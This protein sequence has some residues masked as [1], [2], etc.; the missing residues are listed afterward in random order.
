MAR[1]TK[2][3][4]YAA[5]W[6]RDQGKTNEEIAKELSITIKQV[7]GVMSKYPHNTQPKQDVA[8]IRTSKDFMIRKTSAKENNTVAIMT[9]EA[10]EMN[11]EAKKKN[12]SR[13][14]NNTS[15]IHRIS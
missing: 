5:L 14:K 11:D 7:D 3:Q 13:V 9:K 4:T 2:P 15:N 12:L 6:L 8:A 10:S 1:I